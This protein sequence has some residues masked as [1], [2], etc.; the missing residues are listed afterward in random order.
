MY[1]NCSVGGIGTFLQDL[2]NM[3][4]S[5]SIV[6][7]RRKEKKSRFELG[8]HLVHLYNACLNNFH[9]CFVCYICTLHFKN[10]D[11]FYGKLSF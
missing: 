2:G 10:D 1:I 6:Q 3:A 4:F 8:K 5:F 7:H 9:S 11:A